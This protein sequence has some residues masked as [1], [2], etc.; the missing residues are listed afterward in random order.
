MKF[1]NLGTNRDKCAVCSGQCFSNVGPMT[2]LEGTYDPVC[3]QCV[4]EWAQWAVPIIQRAGE[5]VDAYWAIGPDPNGGPDWDMLSTEVPTDHD[6]PPLGPGPQLVPEPTTEL[7][8]RR[9]TR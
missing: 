8:F 2:F 4:R 7:P 1:N 3:F 6:E 5:L 9:H